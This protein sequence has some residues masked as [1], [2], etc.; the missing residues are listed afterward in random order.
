MAHRYK[1]SV[2]KTIERSHGD[3]D[4][5]LLLTEANAITPWHVD[6][7]GTSVFYIMLKGRKEFA[8]VEP[9]PEN[10]KCFAIYEAGG[11]LVVIFF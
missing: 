7:S 5:Y 4:R 10:K 2:A 11:R 8:V 6:F 1:D 9:T 3:L